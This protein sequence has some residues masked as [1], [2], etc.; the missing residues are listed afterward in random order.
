M[1]EP[2]GEKCWED[3]QREGHIHPR[4]MIIIT[5]DNGHSYYF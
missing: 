2:W 5:N 1:L 3:Q 4:F